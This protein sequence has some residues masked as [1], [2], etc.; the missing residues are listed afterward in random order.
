MTKVVTNELDDIPDALVI[1]Q[2]LFEATDT[3]S[4]S[5]FTSH[6]EKYLLISHEIFAYVPRSM[7]I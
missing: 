6:L 1:L 3:L 7:N 4:A 2:G 5:H